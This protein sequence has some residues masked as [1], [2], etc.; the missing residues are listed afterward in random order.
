MNHV[1]LVE[2][3]ENDQGWI[4]S[5]IVVTPPDKFQMLMDKLRD[6][7]KDMIHRTRWHRLRTQEEIKH[8]NDMGCGIRAKDGNLTW[9]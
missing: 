5:M 3:N 9:S 6:G 4:P 1:Y 2:Y 8:Y 7:Y